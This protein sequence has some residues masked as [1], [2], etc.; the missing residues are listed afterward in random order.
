MRPWLLSSREYLCLVDKR[1]PA[2]FIG[3]FDSGVGGLSV[4]EA[5]AELLPGE[6]LYYVADNGRAP[7]GPQPAADIL[8]YS[9]EITRFLLSKG[10]KMIV[11]AC[12]TATSLA[13]DQL[14]ADFPGIPF[15]GLEPAVKPAAA[16]ACVGVMATEATLAS[17]RYQGL[18]AKYMK[19]K[20]IHEN[21]CVGLVPIIEAEGPGSEVLK[22]TLKSILQPMVAD[23]LDTLV[24]GCT[25]YPLVREDIQSIA[26]P[27]VQI[28]DPA[29][30]AAR[31]VKRLLTKLGDRSGENPTHP[32][33]SG[34]AHDFLC[35]GPSV[36]LQRTLFASPHLNRRR[37]L[38]LPFGAINP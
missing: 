25:H 37:R 24:L 13:I 11:V 6:N 8:A 31:Q 19:G 17:E 20:R 22:R 12:N 7:Y 14:R 33:T 23:G 1:P 34:R 30:A 27:T 28:I 26:G 18:K 32:V 29:P 5:I 9:F 35:T 3:V 2:N 21:P 4:A 10:A 16:G 38:V 36:P 15:V